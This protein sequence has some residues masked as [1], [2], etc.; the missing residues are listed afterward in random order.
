MTELEDLYHDWQQGLYEGILPPDELDKLEKRYYD[1][2]RE[3]N[4]S[5]P[6]LSTYPHVEASV[7]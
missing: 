1:R 5:E 2:F 7:E 4:S 3:I 6:G